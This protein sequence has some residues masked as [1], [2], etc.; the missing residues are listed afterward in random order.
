MHQPREIHSIAILKILVYVKS[1]PG[2][3]LFYRKHEHIRISGYSGSDYANDK[4]IE[5]LLLDIVPL[6][7]K[8][9]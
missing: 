9:L 1:S 7:K 3:G 6:L 8:T 5:N 4:G 2:K